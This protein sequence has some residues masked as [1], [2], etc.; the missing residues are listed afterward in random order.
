MNQPYL[1]FLSRVK[2]K[3]KVKQLEKN[4]YLQQFSMHWENTFQTGK[5][6]AILKDIHQRVSDTLV[7]TP[8]NKNLLLVKM[9]MLKWSGEAVEQKISIPLDM[10]HGFLQNFWFI[11]INVYT[12][13]DKKKEAFP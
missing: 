3:I 2:A 11:A 1:I 4:I 5:I 9:S 12:Q 6:E 8:F 7:C 13:H 10:W